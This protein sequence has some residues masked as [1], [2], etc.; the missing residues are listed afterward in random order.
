MSP[1]DELDRAGRK[2]KKKPS[3][4]LNFTVGNNYLLIIGI[5][6]YKNGIPRLRNAVSD[7]KLFKQTLVEHYQFREEAPYLIELYDEDATRGNII[8]AFD[9][10]ILSLKEEDSLVFYF[11]GHGEYLEHITTG[12][13]VPVD[14][15]NEK[16]YTY[17]TN[18]EVLKTIKSLKCRHVFGVIDSCFS[19]SLF[20]SMDKKK[21]TQRY[22]SKPSRMIVTSGQLEVVADGA[23][24]DQSPFAKKLL[25]QLKNN[26]SD[27][28]RAARLCEGIL[29]DFEFDDSKQVPQWGPLMNVGHGNGQFVFLRKDADW[30]SLVVREVEEQQ[31]AGGGITRHADAA[32]GDSSKTPTVTPPAEPAE[33]GPVPD[34]LPD[35]KFYLEE[36]IAEERISD[37]Y[38]ILKK[39][40]TNRTLRGI[41]INRHGEFRRN[42][43][44]ED[45]GT[46]DPRDL[47]VSYAQIR[48]AF[49]S[50]VSK[51][52]DGDINM[53]A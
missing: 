52:T 27:S 23:L 18:D 50:V 19:G 44:K 33:L 30:E 49:L 7:A 1:N 35:L 43:R 25:S 4:G 2:F 41:L 11:S 21:V 40:I 37:V 28:L 48:Q 36:L 38:D 42:K 32:T 12:Y 24:G 3:S 22:F 26:I 20:R 13:W 8:Q 47:K 5:D 39:K 6:K 9:Q 31:S 10:L 46:A 14:A 45:A 53:K 51:L 16:R 29:E 15:V 34:N 17:L